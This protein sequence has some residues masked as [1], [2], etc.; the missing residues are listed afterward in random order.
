MKIGLPDFSAALRPASNDGSQSMG[1]WSAISAS[2]ITA[3]RLESP[4]MDFKSRAVRSL[5]E[6]HEQEMRRFL[7]VW[8]RFVASSAPMPEAH[9]DESYASRETLVTHV[10]SAARGYLTWIGECV[11]RPVTDVDAEKDPM[12]VAPRARAFAEGVLAAWRRHFAA[13]ADAELGPTLFKTRWGEFFCVETMLEHALAHPMR[14]RIQL[15]RL[16]H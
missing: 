15:E 7:D 9:G 16:I 8:D 13:L 11:G 14:H 1:P 10:V 5:V 6:L 12:R 3:R 4:P 2:Q